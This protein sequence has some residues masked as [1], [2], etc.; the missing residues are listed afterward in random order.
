MANIVITFLQPREK[1]R[2]KLK[3]LNENRCF[4]RQIEP[5]FS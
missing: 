5:T 1:F 2:L 4:G 3:N